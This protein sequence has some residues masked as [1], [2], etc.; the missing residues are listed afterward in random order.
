MCRALRSRWRSLVFVLAMSASRAPLLAQFPVSVGTRVRLTVEPGARHLIGDWADYSSD[1]IT[2]L[3]RGSMRTRIARGGVRLI[4]RSLGSG[5]EAK[6]GA[7]I[8]LLASSALMVYGT[9]SAK[10]GTDVPD[11]VVLIGAALF[12]GA[13]AGVGFLVGRAI[14]WESWQTIDLPPGGQG[15]RLLRGN[16]LV[17]LRIRV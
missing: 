16:L 4:E 17:G 3:S 11:G 8:G 12:A 7:L 2:I 15:S 13:G 1:S 5:N 9:V 10:S 6:K 14:R